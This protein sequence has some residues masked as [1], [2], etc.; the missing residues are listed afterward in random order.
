MARVRFEKGAKVKRIERAVSN[1]TGALKQI[2]ALLVSQGQRAFRMQRLGREA[3]KPRGVPNVF[4]IIADFHAGKRAPPARRFQKRPALRDTGRLASS[5]AFRLVGKDT[6]EAGSNLPYAAVHQAGGRVESETIT[7]KVQR[8]LWSWLK[9]RGSEWKAKLGFLLNKKFRDKKLEGEVPAR[10][11]I[12]I[13]ET[14]RRDIREVVGVEIF[15]A[16]D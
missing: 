15:E 8:L 7:E 9:G 1:P 11:F 13:T 3:W 2:G 4:G 16:R 14:L 5:L 6:V 10:P 12:G